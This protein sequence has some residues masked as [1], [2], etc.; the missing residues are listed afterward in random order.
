MAAGSIVIDLL[1]KTGAFETDTKKAERRWNELT[2]T[3]TSQASK[4]GMAVVGAFTVGSVIKMADEY[5]QMASRI[6][7]STESVE[8]YE[9]VQRRLSETAKLTFRPLVEAQAMYV[10]L[11]SALQ[12]AGKS[13]ELTLDFV[14]SLSFGLVSNA[15]SAQGA[16]SAIK[17]VNTSLLT[18]KVS[19]MS[20]VSILSAAD[21]TASLLAKTMGITE[22]EVR[23]LGAS[24]KL[25][26]EDLF[27]GLVAGLNE[28]KDASVSMSASW[29]DGW[30]KMTNSATEFVGKLNETTGATQSAADVMGFL[31]E[32]AEEVGQIVTILAG[33]MAGKWAT[34]ATA[35]S[36]S[37]GA[38]IAASVRTTLALYKETEAT[39][40]AA[41]A[42]MLYV[43]A[44]KAVLFS[45]GIG[46]VVGL[47]AMVAGFYA[48]EKSSSAATDSLLVHKKTISD[49]AKEYQ[50]L[51]DA[52]RMIRLD[53][54]KEE[55]ASAEKDFDQMIRRVRGADGAVDLFDR[56][57]AGDFE[58]VAD[59]ISELNKRDVYT[60]KQ[61]GQVEKFL[62]GVQD[63]ADKVKFL[64]DQA[65]LLVDENYRLSEASK[66][67]TFDLNSQAS[68]MQGLAEQAESARE[69]IAKLHSEQGNTAASMLFRA[70]LMTKGYSKLQAEYVDKLY[71]L[72]GYDKTQV[73]SENLGKTL[74]YAKMTEGSQKAIQRQEDLKRQSEKTTSAIEKQ[75]K[76][77]EDLWKGVSGHRVLGHDSKYN[78]GAMEGKAGLPRNLI[79][80][81]EMY[82]SRGNTNAV[83]KVGARGT[84]Q[85]MPDTAKQYGVDVGSVKSSAEGFVKYITYLLKRYDNNLDKALTAYHSGEGNV[86]KG[87]IGPQ[88]RQYAKGVLSNLSYLGGDTGNVAGYIEIRD[89]AAERILQMNE[90]IALIGKETEAQRMAAEIDL[91]RFGA[92][93]P[94]Q[95]EA[96]KAQAALLDAANKEY[97]QAQAYQAWL[98][99]FSAAQVFD[100]YR[101]NIEFASQALTDGKISLMEYTAL[102]EKFEKTLPKDQSDW[103]GG[104]IDGTNQFVENAGTIREQ[105]AS[106]TEGVFNTLGD[107]IGNI[108]VGGKASM[109]DMAA[110]IMADLAKIAMRMAM[111]NLING[112]MSM[113][114]PTPTAASSAIVT[115]GSF[116]GGG[117][118]GLYGRLG[119]YA[120]GGYTG[121]GGKWE[122]AGIVHRGEVVFSQADV[123]RH[124]GVDRVEAMRLKG[125]ASGGVVGG[126]AR[127]GGAG[128]GVSIT[129]N[130]NA[131][132]EVE[133]KETRDD[134]GN[135][136]IE[137]M[138]KKVATQTMVSDFAGNGPGFRALQGATGLKRQ[139]Y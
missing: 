35:V 44:N 107:A 92:L 129:I 30:T 123:R 64:K 1:L 104:M 139:G 119:P 19:A 80:A 131:P 106:A 99:Q 132:V 33:I 82:E 54:L 115:G 57:K 63:S 127:S 95:A 111:M 96:L 26:S 11:S 62:N 5:S 9:L 48:I 69:A 124:G 108:A 101:K 83:S 16:E 97:E 91:G 34:S 138:I 43:N 113:F 90:T 21:N 61:L 36:I 56:Y 41:R 78:Y 59:F 125:Y 126:T 118:M 45:T 134:S 114:A 84:M 55:I 51:N 88:G 67:A 58:S 6:R 49:L 29:A 13:T 81:V 38:N 37:A 24:G 15:A 46:A 28:N 60:P 4:M 109:R 94:H 102:M 17:A 66:S 86:D 122:P 85:F 42:K 71:A 23:K 50:G 130:N 103:I 75:Q 117:N 32:N 39:T 76:A 7:N 27:K 79:A 133:A 22:A 100:E 74:N 25:M 47:A 128:S 137:V 77:M 93:L 116:A 20:W 2:N 65:R 73:T 18:G 112:A 68:G 121:A 105:F 110:S 3:V 52:Q 135:V 8:E 98:D 53:G 31:G 12:A 40:A 14:D 10:D 120:E 72:H 87:K 89:L 70:D 136:N